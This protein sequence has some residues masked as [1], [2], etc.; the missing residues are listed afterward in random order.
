MTSQGL[1][2]THSFAF[3][4][5]AHTVDPNPAINGLSHC[6]FECTSYLDKRTYAA[7]VHLTTESDNF[8]QLASAT[9]SSMKRWK[10]PGHGLLLSMPYHVLVRI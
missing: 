8:Y 10:W 3:T 2:K 1:W 9:L 5:S 7:Y 4:Q 6:K